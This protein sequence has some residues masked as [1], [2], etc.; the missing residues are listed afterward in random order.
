MTNDTPDPIAAKRETEALLKAAPLLVA[1]AMRRGLCRVLSPE[2]VRAR[3]AALDVYPD[4]RRR[5][6]R[7]LLADSQHNP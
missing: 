7:E 6:L 2:E 3:A 1:R 4:R 5:T